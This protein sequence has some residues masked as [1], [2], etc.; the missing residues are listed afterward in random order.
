MVIEKG[1][2]VEGM[3]LGEGGR[4]VEEGKD[5]REK[6]K[7]IKEKGIS[8]QPMHTAASMFTDEQRNMPEE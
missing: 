3:W 6:L 5:G 8:E 2:E 4:K 1:E 7:E